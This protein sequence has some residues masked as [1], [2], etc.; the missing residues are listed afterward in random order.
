MTFSSSLD[1]RRSRWLSLLVW[2]V[3][4]LA[5][6]SP[7]LVGCSSAQISVGPEGTGA[8]L[9]GGG[10]GGST[11][12]IPLDAK[13]TGSQDPGDAGGTR[14]VVTCDAGDDGCSCPPFSVAV[15]G[16][17]GKWG[18][19]PQGDPDTALQQWLGSSSAGTARVDNY[20][21]RPT[22]NKDWLDRYNLVILASLADDSNMGP[23][24]TFSTD[25]AAAFRTWIERG[26]G[27]IAL[28]GYAGSPDEVRPTNQLIGFS[29]VAVTTD[30]VWGPTGTDANI[31][32]CNQSNPLTDWNR[33][34]PVVANLSTGVAMIGFTNGRL[35]TSPADGHVVAKSDGK[36]VMAAKVIG[37]GHVVAYGDEWITYT[38]QWNGEGNPMAT[39]ASCK[40]S[41][42]QDKFQIAQLWYNMIHWAQPRATCFT[43][44]DAVVPVV[45]W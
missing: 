7:Q 33:T 27:V 28:T 9:G 18:A 19:N 36:S 17:P 43:I 44:I 29:G 1:G 37:D 38:S 22:L 15:I 13:P 2:S 34:D 31:Y 25:E 32:R 39:D 3:A 45:I 26:G 40:G 8:T 42:A 10:Q 14:Q 11:L 23:W 5:L 30:G 35:V 6:A 20:A 41:L 4:G 12:N 16:K 21:Q 24:W